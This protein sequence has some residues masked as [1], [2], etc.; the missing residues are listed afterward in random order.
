MKQRRKILSVLFLSAAVAAAPITSAVPAFA[1]NM[2]SAESTEF[3][4]SADITAFLAA[5][6]DEMIQADA[7]SAGETTGIQASAFDESSASAEE[8][9]SSELTVANNAGMFK[10]SNA[11]I[12]R[13]AEG[14]S[15]HITLSAKSYH[16]LYKGTYEQALANGNNREN[17][18]AGEQVDGKWNFV[19]PLSE[20]ETYLPLVSIS[21]S[22]LEKYEQGECSLER[23]FFPRQAVI[24]TEAMTLTVGDYDHTEDLNITN[25]VKM[26]SVS[27]AFLQTIGGPNSNGYQEILHLT[28]GSDSFD[29]CFAGSA[30]DAAKAE[31]TTAITEKAV[32][33][34][35]K[36]N[37]AGGSVLYDHLDKDL[38]VSFHSVKNDAWYERVLHVSKADH[39]LVISPVSVS[40]TGIKVTSQLS[41]SIA[42][43]KKVQLQAEVTPSDATD[44]GITWT[45]SNKNVATVNANGLVTIKKNAGGK[46]VTITATAKDGSNISKKITLTCMKGSVKSIKISGNTTVKAGKQVKLTAKVTTQNGSA[47]KKVVWTSS[48]PKL[49]TVSSSG[50]VKTVK[51]KKG[52]VKITASSVD[53]TNKKK[54]ITIKIK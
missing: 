38:V 27:G 4:D 32:S 24:D 46:K 41:T 18:I 53:G 36:A 34:T 45:S 6:E 40:V 48:N 51:G 17:W 31:T 1:E 8:T 33:L 30:A 39:T 23:A 28:M 16:Y 47:N 20:G 15:L 42:A 9:Q 25:N 35:M 5:D 13:T 29:K 49:A 14:S 2:E 44:K 54:T 43:G 52:T 19:I 26:F 7:F 50:V 37:E 11:S 10:V 3:T 21:N 12:Q 22:Y